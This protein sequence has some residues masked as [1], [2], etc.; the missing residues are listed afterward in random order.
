MISFELGKSLRQ[1]FVA[2]QL[3]VPLYIVLEVL[4]LWRSD[5]VRPSG[6]IRA[7]RIQHNAL[8]VRETQIFWSRS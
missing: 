7:L 2:G 6:D 5:L 3:G 8:S 1:H 4:A